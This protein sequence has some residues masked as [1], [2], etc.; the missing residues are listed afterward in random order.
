MKNKKGFTLI[1]L[2]VVI[3]IIGILAVL[4]FFAVS[5]ARAGA[6]DAQRKS[7]ATSIANGLAM[8]ADEKDGSY[9]ATG[10][11]FTPGT[12]YWLTPTGWTTT[13]PA[14]ATSFVG[15]INP[16]A[17]SNRTIVYALG[18]DS[19]KYTLTVLLERTADANPFF[20]DQDG[21]RQK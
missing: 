4:V 13:D 11:T 10:Q 21:C 2:M 9:P 5:R 8:Y 12:N 6:R 7:Q 15:P 16:P 14:G 3:A 1:E 19:T 17:P 18:A 20:C